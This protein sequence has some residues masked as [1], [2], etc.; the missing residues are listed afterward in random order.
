MKIFLFLI[1]N[2]A[3]FS[4]FAQFGTPGQKVLDGTIT[5]SAGSSTTSSM[6]DIKPSDYNVGGSISVAKFTKK[7]F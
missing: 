1:F 6:P 4:S 3:I 7:I 2:C 5:F